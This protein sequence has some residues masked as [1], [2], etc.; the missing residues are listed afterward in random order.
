MSPSFVV[1]IIKIVDFEIFLIFGL[2]QIPQKHFIDL[3]HA[4]NNHWPTVAL[5]SLDNGFP[6]TRGRKVWSHKFKHYTDK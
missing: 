3:I 6:P 2:G 1:D 4:L 5:S